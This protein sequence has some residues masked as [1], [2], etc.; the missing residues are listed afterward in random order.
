[1][2][3]KHK[4]PVVH[5]SHLSLKASKILALQRENDVIALLLEGKSTRE[6]YKLMDLKYRLK[7]GPV[8]KIVTRA[9][10]IIQERKNYEVDTLISLHIARYETI[11][12]KLYEIGSYTHSMNA[13]KA[14][15]VLLGMHK[16]GFHMKVDSGEITALQLQSIDNDYDIKKIDEIKQTRLNELLNKARR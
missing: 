15:E 5:P 4:K 9:R 7:P 1:M 6:I 3:Y 2:A 12:K 13:L 11:Y 8:S 16:D 14:K 10:K